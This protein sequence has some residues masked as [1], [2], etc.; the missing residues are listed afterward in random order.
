MEEVLDQWDKLRIAIGRVTCALP[1][2]LSQA[3]A[4][5]IERTASMDRA[6]N[7]HFLKEPHP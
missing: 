2:Q 7:N 5:L 1:S 4:E 6:L 3:T